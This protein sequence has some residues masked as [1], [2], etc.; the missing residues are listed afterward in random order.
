MSLRKPRI[1]GT[2]EAALA[3]AC[4]VLGFDEAG[5][6]LGHASGS[7]LRQCADPEQDAQVNMRDAAKI[8]IAYRAATGD[9]PPLLTAYLELLGPAPGA[10][11]HAALPLDR[12]MLQFFDEAGELARDLALANTD[13]RISP[14]EHAKLAKD[15][16]DLGTV[17]ERLR[18]DLDHAA[19]N[20]GR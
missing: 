8:D 2:I 10:P 15:L 11:P 19:K 3:R 14:R 16:R 5:S 17:I 4:G 13:A 9:A 12:R 18:R 7:R 6:L 1:P 20:G